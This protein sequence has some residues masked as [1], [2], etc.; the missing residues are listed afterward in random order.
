MDDRK[1][2]ISP[3][4]LD[5]PLG[6]E[7]APIMVDVRRDADFAGAG[8]LVADAFSTDGAQHDPKKDVADDCRRDGGSR[9]SGAG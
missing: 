9:C 7:A 3:D 6:C 8:T 4:A 2:S 5:A 1:H